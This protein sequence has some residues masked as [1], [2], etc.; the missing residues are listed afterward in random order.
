MHKKL[1]IPSRRY[2]DDPKQLMKIHE[3]QAKDLFRGY[4]IPTQ[5]GAVAT[6]PDEAAHAATEFNK[7]VVVKAQVHTGGRGKAGGVKLA[8]TPAEAR[9]KASNIL[10]MSIK[11]IT[12]KKV[13]I[14]D[15]ADIARE[16]YL[17]ITLDRTNKG[18]LFIA[19]AEGGMDIEEV[20]E[21]HPDKILR[22]TVTDRHFPEAEAEPIAAK[23]LGAEQG[24]K[25]L[26]IMRKLFRLFIEKDCSLVEINPLVLTPTGEVVA[27]DG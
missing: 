22:L 18:I 26:D 4:D 12:V 10:G 9:E 5:R 24:P 23:L 1:H 2:R 17:A 13:L 3:Y 19:S 11:G 25:V 15:A 14:A 27:V 21:K 8:K 16:A 20:A 6:T 7:T